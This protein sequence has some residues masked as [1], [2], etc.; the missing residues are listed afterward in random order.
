[1]RKVQVNPIPTGTIVGAFFPDL[2]D[3]EGVKGRIVPIEQVFD[4]M[5]DT[6]SQPSKLILDSFDK[7]VRIVSPEFGAKWRDVKGG[8]PWVMRVLIEDGRFKLGCGNASPFIAVEE[9]AA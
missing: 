4:V 7:D 1:M 5:A 3:A 6:L 8:H 2:Y 9:V